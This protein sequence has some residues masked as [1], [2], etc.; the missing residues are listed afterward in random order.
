MKLDLYEHKKEPY[1]LHLKPGSYF[2]GLWGANGGQGCQNGERIKPGG[3]G[4]FVSA[5]LDLTKSVNLYLFVGSAGENSS[6]KRM[7]SAAGGWN[8]GGRG[9]MDTDNG[10][11]YV[12]VGDD[13]AGGG[14]GATDLRLQNGAS[15]DD[16][17]SL[18]SRILVAAGGSGS[19]FYRNGAPGGDLVGYYTNT[20]DEFVVSLTSQTNGYALGR[21][22]D[23]DDHIIVPSS[24]AGGGY[25][26]GNEGFAGDWPASLTAS[27]GS[28]FAAGY[29]GCE[30]MSDILN[31]KG[32]RITNQDILA[33]HKKQSEHQN[34][35]GL[36]YILSLENFQI[37]N[38]KVA[39]LTSIPITLLSMMEK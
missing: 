15:W 18:K 16:L 4:A 20:E 30:S 31:L 36:A 11:S 8:G 9:G 32:I 10:G 19:Q 34:A 17:E 39:K 26:G 14:G 3:S 27:S 5:R 33:G 6:C 25:Y 13:G 29:E 1:I 35:D 23:G 7:T 22:A 38:Q 24:G 12:G 37:I 28:S 2:V 21:G